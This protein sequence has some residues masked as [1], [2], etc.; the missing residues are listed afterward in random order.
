VA[1]KIIHL[2]PV[3]KTKIAEMVSWMQ[4]EPSLDIMWDPAYKVLLEQD[5]LLLNGKSAR[6]DRLMIADNKV[7]IFDYKTGIKREAHV[8]Q[9]RDYATVLMQMNFQVET[10]ALIYVEEKEVIL[11]Q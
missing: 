3:W 5:I 7:R 10:L 1:Q 9:L 4:E 6:P 8:I 2:N 11:L